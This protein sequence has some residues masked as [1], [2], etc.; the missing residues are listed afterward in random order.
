MTRV[1]GCFLQLSSKW[2]FCLVR[3]ISLDFDDQLAPNAKQG[4]ASL[5][6]SVVLGRGRDARRSGRLLR[7][8]TV[9]AGRIPGQGET[10]RCSSPLQLAYTRDDQPCLADLTPEKRRKVLSTNAARVLIIP[11]Y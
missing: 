5:K 6:R 8:R 1:F 4:L 2:S 7:I 9:M 10:V 11:L 3:S